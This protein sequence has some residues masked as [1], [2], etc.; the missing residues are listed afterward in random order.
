MNRDLRRLRKEQQQAKMKDDMAGTGKFLFLN[1]TKGDFH[2]PR[3]TKEGK[4]IV[5]AGEQ[6]IGDSYYF[7]L[8]KTGELRLVKEIIEDVPST[9]T[10]LSFIFQNRTIEDLTLPFPT[11]EG[12]SIIPPLGQFVGGECYFEL[13]RTGKLKLIKE[14]SN[15]AEEKLLTEIPP[16]VTHNGQVEY[17]KT[18]EEQLNEDKKKKK[19]E[20]TLEGVKLLLE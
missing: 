10:P 20:H 15:M 3:L 8:L 1:N 16:T 2:L 19:N 14:V 5:R 12:S 4:K 7:G 11:K 13:L 9:N 6:F 17:V 18:D